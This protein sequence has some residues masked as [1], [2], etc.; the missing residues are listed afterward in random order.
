M[1][2]PDGV[3]VA[4]NLSPMQ[5]QRGDIVAT[6][7]NALAQTQLPPNRLELEIT[8]TVL[9]EKSERNIHTLD[10]LR[11]LGVTISLDDFGTGFSSSELSPELSR[12]TNSRS[13]SPSWTAY[14]RTNA[15][16][17]LSAPSQ[18]SA[19]PSASRQ[20]LKASRRTPNYQ[21]VAREGCTEVQGFF[22]AR[23]MA[24]EEIPHFLSTFEPAAKPSRQPTPRLW[25]S[26]PGTSAK[27]P[28]PK[29]P[30]PKLINITVTLRRET[31]KEQSVKVRYDEGYYGITV[32]R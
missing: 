13:I 1:S 31:G 15:A 12:W 22:Y 32:L 10:N 27:Y 23:P 4:V 18:A 16:S 2:W 14:H 9:L 28:R 26:A 3:K 20:S 25:N 7:V 21:I 5:F 29:R 24:A 11:A 6:V 8:E 30:L 17:A 19:R